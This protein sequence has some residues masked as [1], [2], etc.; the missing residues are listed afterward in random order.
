MKDEHDKKEAAAR[1][2]AARIKDDISKARAALAEK[3][4]EIRHLNSEVR[5]IK[6]SSIAKCRFY[7]LV[8]EHWRMDGTCKCDDAEHRA[9]MIKSWGYKKKDFDGIPLRKGES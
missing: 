9:M 8:P 4:A 6:Q 7:I 3:E 1:K 2:E 5:V